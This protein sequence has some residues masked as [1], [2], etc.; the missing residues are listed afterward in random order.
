M[1]G[2]RKGG[3]DEVEG[4]LNIGPRGGEARQAVRRDRREC[5]ESVWEGKVQNV[6]SVYGKARFRM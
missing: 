4:D 6:G 1:E 5:R 2:K 3:R